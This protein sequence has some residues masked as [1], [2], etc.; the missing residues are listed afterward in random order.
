MAQAD[1]AL[2]NFV[3]AQAQVFGIEFLVT[4]PVPDGDVQQHALPG[5]RGKNVGVGGTVHGG[6]G[7]NGHGL[8]K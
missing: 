7:K 6:D 8:K 5:Q 3:G 4:A 2:R 1:E